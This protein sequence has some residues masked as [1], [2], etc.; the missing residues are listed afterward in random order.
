QPDDALQRQAILAELL[1]ARGIS[2]FRLV[3]DI[4]GK[5]VLDVTPPQFISY[6]F[7]HSRDATLPFGVIGLSDGADLGVDCT[8]WPEAAPDPD[9]W[10]SIAAPEEEHL[11]PQ[12][13]GDA[14]ILWVIKESALKCVGEVMIDPRHIAA[15][16]AANGIVCVMTS[17]IVRKPL[18]KVFVRLFELYPP[19]QDGIRF[20][21]SVASP[22]AN[23]LVHMRELTWRRV[24][25]NLFVKPQNRKITY[26]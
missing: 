18:P 11:M 25:L 13:S 6:S 9:F 7:A 21:L 1:A 15:G 2:S 14:R 16:V 26:L 24:A 23:F 19:G 12:L 5:P 8:A 22:D 4:N 3:R 20:L 17:S 10:T